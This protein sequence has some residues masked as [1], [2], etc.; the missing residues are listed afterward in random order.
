MNTHV[1]LTGGLGFIASHT[2]EHWLKNT[3]WDITVIDSLRHTGRVERLTDMECYDPDRVRV[4]WHD[5]RSEF[6]QQLTYEIGDVDY[7]V[8]MASDSHVDRS[9]KDP[10][11]FI[12]NNVMSTVN[13]LEY[14]REVRPDMF[15]QISTDEVYGPAV[16]PHKHV[17][18]ET[19]MPSNPYSASKS[20]QEQIAFAYWRTYDVPVVI[21]N[22]MNNF[23]EKQDMEK[24]VPMV[25][26]ALMNGDTITVH[27]QQN[28][29]G[30]WV[31][32]SR[33]WLHARNHADALMFIMRNVWPDAYGEDEN[34]DFITVP[35][36]FNIVGDDEVDNL[37]IVNMLATLMN[38]DMK[39]KFVDFH[40][41]RPGHD[42]R[43][44]LDGTKLANLGWKAPIPMWE[45]MRATVDW[46]QAN[47]EWL[48]YS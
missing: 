36:R 27:A 1:L 43:Y 37:E 30:T 25:I 2:I 46:Y 11:P 17:E 13:A 47:P 8:N 33:F 24:Y 10:V 22:T 5:M 21:T 44:A 41:S 14:A 45:S 20:A 19:A 38:T 18:W 48:T 35:P 40:S 12:H 28:S 6:H 26:R 7:L 15:I 9:I 32:G 42:M 34:G 3:D 29:E 31:P 16:D 23:G 4:L 39:W